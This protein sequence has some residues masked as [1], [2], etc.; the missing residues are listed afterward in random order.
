MGG[1][2][3]RSG[4]P[5]S[6]RPEPGP[7][8]TGRARRRVGRGRLESRAW[9]G[10]LAPDP[11][12]CASGSRTNGL[13]RVAR[14]SRG[15]VADAA[16]TEQAE[17][18]ATTSPGRSETDAG[19]RALMPYEPVDVVEV[20]CWNSRVG[21]IARDPTSGFYAFEYAPR[22]VTSAVELA[23]ISM[24]T[25]AATGPFVFPTLP[26][27]TYRRL[28][29]MIADALPDDFGNA[30]DH[31]V[32]GQR[33][34]PTRG[35]HATRSPGVSRQSWS[36]SARVPSVPRPSNPQI[37]HDRVVGTGRRSQERAGGRHRQ[38]GR[39]HRRLA[40]PRSRV[41]TS[42]G[43]AGQ[44]GGGAQPDDGRAALRTSP[45]RP[46]LRAVAAASSTAWGQTPISA[47]QATSAALSTPTT[48]WRSQPAST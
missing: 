48:A 38:R 29:A 32:P 41:G 15:R 8:A 17:D 14:T 45:R 5:G 31:G 36:R 42:A 33:R 28:P 10:L 47:R 13:D 11:D 40:A 20:R 37:D 39:H 25:T 12:R 21:A 3:R 18:T 46:R 2:S 1:R 4:P 35:H 22:W 7:G 23:P 24:P 30:L 34:H 26:I 6:D 19:R 43:G 44:G 16:V 9:E 27:E